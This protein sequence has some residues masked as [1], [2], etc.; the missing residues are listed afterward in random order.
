MVVLHGVRDKFARDGGEEEGR[1][2]D[3]GERQVDDLGG[4]GGREWDR[5]DEEEGCLEWVA[6]VLGGRRGRVV[7]GWVVPAA[8]GG[9]R[10]E[11]VR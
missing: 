9:G 4:A 5:V 10:G 11:R 7:L 1:T 8:G 6:V 2:R 3:G